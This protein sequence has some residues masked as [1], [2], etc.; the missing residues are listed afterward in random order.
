MPYFPKNRV[1][2]NLYTN[3][4]EYA[5]KTTGREY[6]GPYYKLYTG[7]AFTGKNPQDKPTVE[8]IPYEQASSPQADT[9]GNFSNK[10]S[11]TYAYIRKDKKATG[12]ISNSNLPIPKYP[13]LTNSDYKLGEFERYFLVKRNQP[14]YIEILEGDYKD[15]LKNRQSFKYY[16]YRP[17]KLPWKITGDPQE[18]VN[19]NRNIVLLTEK[20]KELPQFSNYLTNYTEFYSLYTN[21]GEFTYEDGTSYVGLYHVMSNGTIMVG[22]NHTQPPNKNNTLYPINQTPLSSQVGNY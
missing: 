22:I 16:L 21:G 7:Y 5:L 4:G 13:L 11:A 18:V 15:C 17:F 19:T 6:I 2:S 14:L 20:N 8:L 9:Y 1:T 3:G 10:T 12:V